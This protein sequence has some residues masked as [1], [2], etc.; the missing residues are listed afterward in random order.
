MINAIKVL[1]QSKLLTLRGLWYLIC[2]IRLVGINLM[3]VLYVSHRFYPHKMAFQDETDHIDFCTLYKQSQHL[4]DQLATLYGVKKGQRVAVMAYNHIALVHTLFALSVLGADIYLLN[5][6]MSATQFEQL[7]KK[8]T[9]NLIIHDADI[10]FLDEQNTLFT[11]HDSLPSIQLLMNSPLLVES[12]KRRINHFAKIIVLTSGST[13]NFKVAERRTKAS[14]FIKPFTELLIKLKLSQYNRIYI[15]TP[16]YHGFGMATFC[17]SVLL[18]ATGFLR[19]KFKTPEASL[20]LGEHKVEVITLVPLMLSRLL[21]YDERK[22]I[23]LKCIIT[24]GAPITEVLVKETQRKLGK[25]LFNLYG[26]SEAGICTIATPDDLAKHPNSIGVPIAGLHTKLMRDGQAITKGI[27]ELYI[28]CS[29]SIR[30]NEWIATG[31]LAYKDHQHYFYL[32]GRVDDMI[33]SAGENVYPY[34]LEQQLLKHPLVSEV[35]VIAITD[36][37]FGQRLVAFVV[38]K[39]INELSE[40]TLLSW[41][42]GKIARYQMPKKIIQLPEIPITAIG[43]PNKKQ[44]LAIL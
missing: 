41:L 23:S 25:V 12:P 5:A 36:E 38:P 37:E 43:K 19:K 29:W 11:Y 17:I 26:T 3:A 7:N 24:G 30:A 34:S 6:E 31:D 1:Y 4:A 10:D 42:S 32:Q 33:V 8:C 44:L 39:R 21:K 13:G 35:F 22:L 40:Q 20:L 15:A 16:I 14:S 9:F 28:K 27:G 18:G 2:A